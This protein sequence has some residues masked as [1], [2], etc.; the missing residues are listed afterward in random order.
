MPPIT[1]PCVCDACLVFSSFP[2]PKTPLYASKSTTKAIPNQDG[3]M[4][5]P[6][7]DQSSA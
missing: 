7:E 6:A 3:K 2:P 1:H 4:R 5:S